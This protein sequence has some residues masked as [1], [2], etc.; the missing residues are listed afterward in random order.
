[1]KQPFLTRPQHLPLT[2]WCESGGVNKVQMLS[3]GRL[4]VCAAEGSCSLNCKMGLFL[5]NTQAFAVY[6]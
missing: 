1:M 3:Y 5:F 4:P 6:F 2:K